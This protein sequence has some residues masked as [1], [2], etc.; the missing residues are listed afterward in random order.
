M[1][2]LVAASPDA[3]AEDFKRIPPEVVA[4]ERS[5][6]V[7]VIVRLVHPPGTPVDRTQDAVLAEL[8][9]T[10]YRILHRYRTSPFLALEVA[11][12]ALRVLDR[13]AHVVS[14]AGDREAHTQDPGAKR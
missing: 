12:N 6:P 14:V 13:S 1:I 3:R 10:S 2:A 4:A 5:G 8:A 7:R 11:E 9:G